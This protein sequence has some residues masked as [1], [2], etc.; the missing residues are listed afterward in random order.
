MTRGRVLQKFLPALIRKVS[1]EGEKGGLPGAVRWESPSS[2]EA[3][4]KRQG[5]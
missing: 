5:E 2:P 1:G 3:K 4:I